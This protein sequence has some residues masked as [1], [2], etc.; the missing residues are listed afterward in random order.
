M[1]IAVIGVGYWG[2]NIV[3]NLLNNKA[4]SGVYCFDIDRKRLRAVQAQFP[5]VKIV[6]SYEEILKDQKIKG[7]CIATPASTHFHLAKMA[8]EHNKH[9]FIEKPFTVSMAEAETLFELSR[10]KGLKLIVDHIF[11][12]HGAI[13]KIKEIIASGEIG[14]ILYF[15]A[16]RINLG[17][18][19]HDVNVLWDLATHDISVMLYLLNRQ[20]KTVS[21]IALGHY[22]TV[23]DIA[24][25]TMLFGNNCIAHIHVNWLA[26]VKV[27]RILIGGSKKMILYDD[28]E[29]MEKIKVFDKGVEIKTKEGI[30]KTLVQYRTG[31]MYA[32]KFDTTEPLF[33]IINEFINAIENGVEPLS[34][35]KTGMEVVKILCAAEKSVKNNGTIVEINE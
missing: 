10:K 3:R 22:N 6:D 15:D 35:A 12:Y 26:P 9:L 2:P 34:N 30:Y 27:R 5:T 14:E 18:F 21:A 32:P 11:M 33:L 4:V 19:Q 16:V 7:V 8:I 29:T 23:E 24:Y 1:K 28:M 13:K 31:D 25:L 20:P 17:L